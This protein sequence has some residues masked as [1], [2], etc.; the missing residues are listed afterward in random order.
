MALTACL[1]DAELAA[2]VPCL[3]KEGSNFVYSKPGNVNMFHPTPPDLRELNTSFMMN[4]IFRKA[5]LSD[6]W[7]RALDNNTRKDPLMGLSRL[8]ARALGEHF[9]DPETSEG[10]VYYPNEI[11]NFDKEARN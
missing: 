5:D 11:N 9:R 7:M 8:T 1:V 10:K 2:R 3:S 6:E 4:M